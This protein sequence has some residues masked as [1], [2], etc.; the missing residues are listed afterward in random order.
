MMATPTTQAAADSSEAE[1][2]IAQDN[3]HALIDED[4]CETI[5]SIRPDG[6]LSSLISQLEQR[7]VDLAGEKKAGLLAE[8]RNSQPDW[9]KITLDDTTPDTRPSLMMRKFMAADANAE[10]AQADWDRRATAFLRTEETRQRKEWYFLYGSLMDPRQLQR[11]LGLRETPRHLRPA[12]IIG[13]HTRLWGPY[14]VLLNGPPGNVVKGMGYEIEGGENKD[15][16]A[17]YETANYSEHKCLIRFGE[18]SVIGATFKWAGDVGELKDGSFD[19][20]DWQ[21]ARWLED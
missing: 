6:D 5:R 14:P 19:L 21:M 20:K 3:I 1:N 8:P 11:V 13:Y 15:K 18:E 2:V 12:E 16:L 7:V 9:H 10:E 17:A 4:I